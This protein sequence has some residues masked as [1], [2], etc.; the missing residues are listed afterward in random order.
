MD[1]QGQIM[2]RLKLMVARQERIDA[3]RLLCSSYF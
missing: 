2:E 3:L 1:A